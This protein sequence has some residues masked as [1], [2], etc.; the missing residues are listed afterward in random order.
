MHNSIIRSRINYG[1]RLTKMSDTENKAG[2]DK[3]LQAQ[4]QTLLPSLLPALTAEEVG[5][6][7]PF[8]Q[9]KKLSAGH[10]LMTQGASDC[11]IYFLLDGAFMVFEK[12]RINGSPLVLKTAEFPGPCILGEVNILAEGSR[13]ATVVAKRPCQSWVLSEAKFAE[14]TS[15]NPNLAIRLLK[16]FGAII[17]RRQKA[18]QHRVR[19]NILSDGHSVEAAIHKLGRYTGKVSRADKAVAERLFSADL[20]GENYT[21]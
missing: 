8:L 5:S 1:L 15:A 9:E 11:E 4:L 6:L 12:I 20:D 14:I 7:I 19:G 16:A 2:L 21:T 10:I 17:Y 13:S 3:Q 18:F